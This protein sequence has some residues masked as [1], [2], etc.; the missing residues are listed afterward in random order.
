M[1]F[2]LAKPMLEQGD[3]EQLGRLYQDLTHKDWF[4]ALLDLEDYIRVKEQM[5]ADYEDRQ[6]WA[7]KM[8]INIAQA[9]YFSSDRTIEEYNREIWK[10]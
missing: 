1:D 9:G 7:K 3:A 6:S 4:M 8:M 5:F 2:L 10:L